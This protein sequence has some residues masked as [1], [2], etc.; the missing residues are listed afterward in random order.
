MHLWR[1][2]FDSKPE[3]VDAIDL[4]RGS[5]TRPAAVERTWHIQDITGQTVR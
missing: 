2:K 5:D 3:R 4:P 1:A